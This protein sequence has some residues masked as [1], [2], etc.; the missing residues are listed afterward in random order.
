MTKMF[1][2]SSKLL[3]V[4]DTE[5]SFQCFGLRDPGFR[6]VLEFLEPGRSV[7]FEMQSCVDEYGDACRLL[8]FFK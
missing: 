7:S 6:R 1:D 5:S 8:I 2:S 4:G 3:D